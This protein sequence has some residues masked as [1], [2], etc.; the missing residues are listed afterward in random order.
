MYIYTCIHIHV[1]VCVCVYIYIDIY[2][3]IIY[4]Y[5]Y[6]YMYI[7]T[8]LSTYIYIHIHIHIHVQVLNIDHLGAIVVRGQAA[9]LRPSRQPSRTRCW[10]GGHLRALRNPWRTVGPRAPALAALAA[11]AAPRFHTRAIPAV[12]LPM[13]LRGRRRRHRL[14]R[15]HPPCFARTAKGPRGAA[16]RGR[17]LP[18]RQ[19]LCRARIAMAPR[20]AALGDGRA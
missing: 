1:N 18:H 3:D 6:I 10:L 9:S 2:I 16:R 17:M 5:I 15:R 11:L 20:R 13:R 4:I 8:H 19:A 7:Y 14:P 12:V